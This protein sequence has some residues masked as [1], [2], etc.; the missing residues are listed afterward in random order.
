MLPALVC[1]AVG[2]SCFV[3]ARTVFHD[4]PHGVD[5]V[6]YYFQAQV[7]ASGRVTAPGVA[8]VD[9]FDVPTIVTS[10]ERRFAIYPPGWPAL[11]AVALGIGA[12]S[13]ANAALA[14]LCAG[15]VWLTGRIIYGIREAWIA[16]ALL[17]MSPFFVFMGAGYLSHMAATTAVCACLYFMLLS[18]RAAGRPGLLWA[19]ASGGAAGLAFDVRPFSAV[20]GVT[21]GLWVA[22]FTRDGEEGGWG[23]KLAAGGAT[24]IGIGSLF[25]VYNGLTTG[26]PLLTGYHLYSEEFGLFGEKW[27][28]SPGRAP[29]WLLNVTMFLYY[30]S[31]EIWGGPY[32]DLFLLIAALPVRDRRVWSVAAAP[33]LFIAGHSVF[34][35][36]GLYHGP[37]FAFM[38]LPLILLASA[39]GATELWRRATHPAARFGLVIL[40]AGWVVVGPVR[41][42]PAMATYY[43][44]N[45]Q[46]QGVALLEEVER[47]GLSDALVFVSP[48]AAFQNLLHQNAIELSESR[49]LFSGWVPSEVDAVSRAY[50]RRERWLLEVD[51]PELPGR[52]F[53]PDRFEL[54]DARWRRLP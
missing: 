25:F 11:L 47:R 23:Q 1:L 22:W 51:L 50:P 30:L 38:A 29:Y 44:A 7:F 52:N 20:L 4:I 45:Y 6:A 14:A 42:F 10:Q 28:L 3:A 21:C 40:A 39:R 12:P 16:L 18:R 5:A 13:L 19:V 2:A 46:G 34:A 27:N 53:Y 32:T 43:R 36:F 37:R 33:L 24:A 26:E 17:A 48:P 49:V 9:A 41:F 54:T 35:I 8:S 31:H 15:F